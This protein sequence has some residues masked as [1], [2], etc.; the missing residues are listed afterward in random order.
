[1]NQTFWQLFSQN[2]KFFM[3]KRDILEKLINHYSGGNKAKF[4]ATIGVTPQLISNWLKRNTFDFEQ[5]YKGCPNVSGDYLLSGIG[6][7]EHK[8][9]DTL[10]N[11]EDILETNTPTTSAKPFYGNLP[12]SA[13]VVMQYPNILSQQATG[14]IDLPQTHGAEFFFPVIGMSMKPTIEEGEIIGVAH[15][16]RLETTN[17]DRI[18]M[19]ITRDGERMIKRILQYNKE[20]GTITL[21]SDNPNF[22][23]NELDVNMLLDVYKVM[24]HMRIETL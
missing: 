21:G 11:I 12:V 14:L 20:R 10:F 9:N 8:Q 1:M 23:N 4:A 3:E 15:I 19:L 22:P 18:Y 6:E 13:G 24:F 16:D 17:A 7:I 5:V 2:D